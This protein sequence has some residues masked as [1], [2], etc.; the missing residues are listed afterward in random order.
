MLNIHS[1]LMKQCLVFTLIVMSV[2]AFFAQQ[3]PLIQRVGGRTFAFNETHGDSATFTISNGKDTL[4][5]ELF[6]ENGLSSIRKWRHDSTYFYRQFGQIA[7]KTYFFYDKKAHES[8]DSTAFYRL[9]GGLQKVL[10]ARRNQKTRIDFDEHNQ[11]KEIETQTHLPLNYYV[12]TIN[13]HKVRGERREMQLSGRDSFEIHY[14]TTFYPHNRIKTIEHTRTLQSDDDNDAHIL[15]KDIYDENGVQTSHFHANSSLLSPFKDNIACYYGFLNARGDTIIRARFDNIEKEGSGFFICKEGLNEILMR[16]N[17]QVVSTQKM[18]RL[19]GITFPYFS[20]FSNGKYGVIDSSGRTILPPQYKHKITNYEKE[21]SVFEFREIVD[22]QLQTSGVIDAKT[23]EIIGG[24]RFK[25]LE[26]VA[27]DLFIFSDSIGD[28]SQL[29]SGLVN[30]QGEVILPAQYIGIKRFDNNLFLVEQ[31]SEEAKQDASILAN[32]V[33]SGLFDA[34]NKRWLIEPSFEVRSYES[35]TPILYFPKT[36][37]YG[38][39]DSVGNWILPPV[40]DHIKTLDKHD[41]GKYE[42]DLLVVQKGKYAIL[43]R[44]KNR[45]V[46]QTYDYLLG[47]DIENSPYHFYRLDESYN[48]SQAHEYFFIAKKQGKW[49]IINDKD[50]VIVPFEYD[51]VGQ[52]RWNSEAFVKNNKAYKLLTRMY[53]T[54]LV[55]EGQFNMEGLKQMTFIDDE[56]Q[57]FIINSENRVVIPP[58][59]KVVSEYVTDI[60]KD[61]LIYRTATVMRNNKGQ[62]KIAYSETGQILDYPF[63]QPIAWTQANCPFIWLDTTS[64][65]RYLSLAD[66]RTGHIIKTLKKGGL[67]LADTENGSFFLKTSLPPLLPKDSELPDV[68]IDTLVVDDNDWLMY[69]V[70]NKQIS[71]AVF[72]FPIPFEGGVGLGMV[73][74]KYGLWQSDGKELLPPQYENGICVKKGLFAL[75]QNIG[76]KNWLVLFD[77]KGKNLVGTGR[78]D[79]ISDFYGKYALVKN[80]EKIGLIDTLGREIVP[81]TDI[82]SAININFKDSLVLAAVAEAVVID[83]FFKRDFTWDIFNS[84]FGKSNPDSLHLSTELRNMAWNRILEVFIFK[85]MYTAGTP[86]IKRSRAQKT[87]TVYSEIWEKIRYKDREKVQP[88]Q[89]FELSVD[90]T[91]MGFSVLKDTVD[92]SDYYNFVKKGKEWHPLS[93]NE[94]FNLYPDNTMKINGLL[95]QKISKLAHLDIDCGGSASFWERGQSRYLVSQKGITFYFVTKEDTESPTRDLEKTFVPVFVTWAEAKPFLKK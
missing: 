35:K 26:A 1:F 17:G 2:T 65:D 9:D 43:N 92:R 42:R 79:G 31:A 30:R 75:F 86:K 62:Q 5:T 85:K 59:Y 39:I 29:Y 23:G 72:R 41:V 90:S 88:E 94:I 82:Q 73:G 8:V 18:S 74:D 24:G 47:F 36:Q 15:R 38:M 87:Y 32:E 11:I 68:F 66:L 64:K 12:V 93:T 14:D 77:K 21:L 48:F 54:Q 95:A 60:D 34:E 51:Y 56:T 13:N 19:Y 81:L 22:F 4:L 84:V 50:A 3:T 52:G 33:K 20:F 58:Q 91:Y 55:G 49:G 6:F 53:P 83:T 69:D 71:K 40:Y 80:G 76:L 44:A 78:Y 27:H 63:S 61:N 28:K 45:I 70:A 46:S 10:I 37:K 67:S 7:G 57:S 89:L 25:Q 16:S